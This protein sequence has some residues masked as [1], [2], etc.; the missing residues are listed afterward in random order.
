[1]WQMYQRIL[2]AVDGSLAATRALNEAIRLATEQHAAL[3][4]MHVI[5]MP[6]IADGMNVDFN[7]LAEERVAPGRALLAEAGA[8]IRQAGIEPKVV[9]RSSDGVRVGDVI[10]AEATEWSAELI[11]L[12]THGHGLVQQLLGST[13][14]DVLR[15]TP[16]PILLIRA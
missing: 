1:M 12:G 13:T 7:A 6:Y 9:L 8:Q 15:S 3:C 10:V 4:L 5:E 14:E 2:V 16:V 11:V